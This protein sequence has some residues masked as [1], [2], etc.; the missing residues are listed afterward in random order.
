MKNVLGGRGCP[1][2]NRFRNEM[3]MMDE[4]LEGQPSQK[5]SCSLCS[6]HG[7]NKRKCSKTKGH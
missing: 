4:W 2:V 3:D 1:Q 7:H 5:Q 6:G